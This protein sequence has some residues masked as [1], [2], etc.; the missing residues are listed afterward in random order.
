MNEQKTVW[1]AYTNTDLTEGRGYDVPIAVC[2][3]KFTAVRLARKKYVQ[4]GDGP[5]R[6]IDMLK[7]D[8]KWYVPSAAIYIVSPTTEDAAAQKAMEAKSQAL[9]KVMAAGLTDDD[10]LALGIAKEAK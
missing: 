5:V 3:A 6:A 4:G 2:E 7:V 8:D 1:V 9:A 10:L